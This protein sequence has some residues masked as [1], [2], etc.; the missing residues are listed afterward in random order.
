MNFLLILENEL[1]PSNY[2]RKTFFEIT[3]DLYF[4]YGL[5]EIYKSIIILRKFNTERILHDK[6]RFS[7][8]FSFFKL[9]IKTRVIG[10]IESYYYGIVPWTPETPRIL[11]YLLS[12]GGM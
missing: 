12:K 3:S 4:G 2:N 5:I 6:F 1:D 11:D 10:W 7:W 9:V 8:S